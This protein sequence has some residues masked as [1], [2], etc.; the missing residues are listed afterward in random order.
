MSEFVHLLNQNG[1]SIHSNREV[2]YWPVDFVSSNSRNGG[3]DD[4][5]ISWNLHVHQEKIQGRA[6]IF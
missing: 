4:K 2:G 6:S 1:N 5:H 3:R